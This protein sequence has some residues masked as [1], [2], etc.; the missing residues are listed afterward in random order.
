MKYI[1][2]LIARRLFVL[3]FM[4]EWIWSLFYEKSDSIFSKGW[5]QVNISMYKSSGTLRIMHQE[6]THNKWTRAWLHD[7]CLWV[8]AT[9]D[10]HFPECEKIKLCYSSSTII[11][12]LRDQGHSQLTRRHTKKAECP[13]HKGVQVT[14]VAHHYDLLPV[15]QIFRDVLK[16]E[17]HRLH[18]CDLKTLTKSKRQLE[19]ERFNMRYRLSHTFPICICSSFGMRCK[20]TPRVS[21]RIFEKLA[22]RAWT[23]EQAFNEHNG[24]D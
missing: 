21:L 23:W 9:E 20:E 15:V 17:K 4:C 24:D 18:S 5:F 22:F 13:A 19:P 16:Q 11:S 1:S 14:A 12:A 8:Y 2:I 6:I 10:W 3:V 7:T